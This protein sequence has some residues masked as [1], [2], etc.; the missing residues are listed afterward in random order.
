MKTLHSICLLTI[1]VMAA[2]AFAW[3]QTVFA[4]ENE[5]EQTVTV[6]QLPAAV[7]VTLLR[8]STGGTIGEIEKKTKNGDIIYEAD[9]T[10]DGRKYEAKVT[11]D[12]ILIKKELEEIGRAHV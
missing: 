2:L 4:D 11:E 6:Q 9:I 8:E 5:Q 3:P 1:L 7:R 12:G 10:L